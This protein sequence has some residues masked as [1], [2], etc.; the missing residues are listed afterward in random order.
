MLARP[1]G[2]VPDTALVRLAERVGLAPAALSPVSIEHDC[3]QG[4]LLGFTNISE[5][6][7]PDAAPAVL[8]AIGSLLP[9]ASHPLTAPDI[10]AADSR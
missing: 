6:H 2:G 10:I 3:G 4:L 8:R 5:E 9:T 7:A 1:S